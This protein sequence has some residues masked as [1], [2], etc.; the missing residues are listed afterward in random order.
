[1]VRLGTVAVG[2]VTAN[3]TDSTWEG[4]DDLLGP[5]DRDLLTDTDTGDVRRRIAPESYAIGRAAL[6]RARTRTEVG[7]TAARAVAGPAAV[8]TA[9][10]ARLGAALDVV[11][12]AGA[13]TADANT[14]IGRAFGSGDTDTCLQTC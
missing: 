5:V 6:E 10:A 4:S 2:P 13:G 9:V 12:V 7:C 3:L 11:R 14:A 1:M 8:A